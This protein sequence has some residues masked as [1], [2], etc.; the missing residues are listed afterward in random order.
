MKQ[1]SI[2][3]TALL[4]MFVVVGC[5][6]PKEFI[7]SS[8]LKAT[9]NPLELK[10]GLIECTV[11][12]NFPEKYFRKNMELSVVPV[13]KSTKTGAVL[14]GQEKVY[15]GEKIKGNNPVINY[16]KGGKYEQKAIFSYDSQ[17]DQC[18]LYLEATVKVKKKVITLEPVK[19]ADGLIVTPNL[20]YSNPSELG[21]KVIKDN[22][23]RVKE[24]KEDAE[25]KFLIQQANVRATE[26]KNINNLTENIK[27]ASQDSNLNIK[28]LEISSY[29]SPDG[30]VEL[31]EKLAEARENSTKNY[32]NSQMKKLKAEFD[33][34]GTF[35]AQDWEGFKQLMDNSD[36]QD[37]ELI[38]SVLSMYSDPEQRE[39]EIKNLSA[40]FTEIKEKILPQLRRSK[41]TMTKEI[42]GKS[43]VEIKRLAQ[44]DPSK[45]DAEELLYAAT[46]YDNLESQKDIYQKSIQYFPSDVRGY[47]NLG[48]VEYELG[49]VTAADRNFSKALE[50][51]ANNP[52]ANLNK[53]SILISEGRLGE[54]KTYLGNAAGVGEE[55]NYANGAIAIAEGDYYKAVTLYGAANTNNS[56][57]ARILNKDYS[58]ARNILSNIEK[59]DAKT[60][61]LQSIV[62][63][64]TNNVNDLVKS[65]TNA[66]NTDRSYREKYLNDL[67]FRSFMS[68]EA[69]SALVK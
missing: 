10:G 59:P 68:N 52:A 32:I 47:N 64:R 9:P 23:E 19:V 41:I 26:A 62:A 55:L 1:R 45:L 22:F 33:I 24:E 35:T 49:N 14:R 50:I 63:A 67:E 61:Y 16:K 60:Y 21:S 17:F 31:N 18:E 13:L 6:I 53:A 5:K 57:L 27:K 44:E 4:V 56:A 65:A 20:I 48:V 28:K 69:F 54:A 38:L 25:I 39:K 36:I 40:A 43:D 37:K 51:D 42:M 66:I 46:L 2:I 11:E 3:F 29:A 7:S 8:G 30:G 58:G 34:S 15:Q 12:G